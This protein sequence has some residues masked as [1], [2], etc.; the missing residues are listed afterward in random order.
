MGNTVSSIQKTARSAGFYYLL[1]AVC[2]FYG[3]SESFAFASMMITKGEILKKL[4]ISQKQ[5]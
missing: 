3:I 4:D 1:V 5:D 2:G